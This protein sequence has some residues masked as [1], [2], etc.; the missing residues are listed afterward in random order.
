MEASFD[1][2]GNVLDLGDHY[3]WLQRLAHRLLRDAS[4][5]DDAVQDTW[6]VALE[7][8]PGKGTPL[9]PWLAAVLRR[10]VLNTWRSSER[11]ATHESAAAD[12]RR[13][14]D[15]SS[16]SLIEQAESA[17]VLMEEVRHLKPEQMELVLLRYMHGLSST[18]IG[19]RRNLSPATVRW[20]LKEARTTLEAR[21][22]KRFGSRS[23]WCTALAP[24][25]ARAETTAGLGLGVSLTTAAVGALIAGL[26]GLGLWAHFSEGDERSRPTAALPSHGSEE[27]LAPA[28]ELEAVVNEDA[29][30]IAGTATTREALSVAPPSALELDPGQCALWIQLVGPDNRPFE[31]ASIRWIDGTDIFARTRNDGYAYLRFRPPSDRGHVRLE[32]KARGWATRSMRVAIMAGDTTYPPPHMMLPERT[33]RGR[34]VDLEG[35]PQAGATIVFAPRIAGTFSEDERRFGPVAWDE[36]RIPT[37]TTGEDGTFRASGLPSCDLRVFAGR[38]DTWFAFGLAE[39][40][41]EELELSLETLPAELWLTGTLTA[42][43]GRTAEGVR[44]IATPL[45]ESD[46]SRACTWVTR[47]VHA[48]SDADGHYRL[49][50]R[51]SSEY[52]L[53]AED[54]ADRWANVL[55]EQVGPGQ[56]VD[57]PLHPLTP[58]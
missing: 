24:F 8:P 3:A 53:E 47:P 56:R 22:E 25:G 55:R 1:R 40:F 36:F 35:E 21:L 49:P 57:L 12:T 43:G 23:A 19:R 54:P 14:A 42:P 48:E 50:L 5:A 18:E 46:T 34:V 10:R 52:R 15:P 11:R 41:T 33:L 13:H 58:R 26:C 44:L 51:G 29:P 39:S 17:Q 31:G 37:V 7:K 6:M 32:A 20:Q 4:L 2:M 38:R 45:E 28:P 16:E 30:T 27:P 9:R